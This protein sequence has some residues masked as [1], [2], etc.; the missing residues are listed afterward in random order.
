VTTA[1]REPAGRERREAMAAEA[2]RVLAAADRALAAGY[3]GPRPGRQPVH[4]AYLPA[5]R[6]GP[7]LPA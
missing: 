4:T 6:F 1:E 5:D 2:D 3:P 7:G